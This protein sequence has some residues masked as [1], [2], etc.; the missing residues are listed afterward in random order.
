MTLQGG[1]IQNRAGQG[2]CSLAGD[3]GVSLVIL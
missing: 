3:G 1:V 2:L